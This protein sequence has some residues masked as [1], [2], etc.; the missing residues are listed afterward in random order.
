[1]V[2]APNTAVTWAGGSTQTVTWNVSGTTAS[3]IST[4]N[5]NIL[6]STDGGNTF[7]TVI[8]AT[9]ANDG[10]ESITV[11]NTATTT[12]RIKVE[13]VGNI[14]F[15]MSNTN[16]TITVSAGL[17]TIT[18]SAISPT[19]YCDGANVNVSYTINAAPNAGNVFTAQLSNSAGSFASPTAI[20][21]LTTTAAGT[22]AATIPAGTATGSGY[23]IRIVSSSPVVTG[24]DNGT[25]ITVNAKPVPSITG[26][27]SF[28]AG[29][30]T[31][32]NAGS[33]FSSYNWSTGATTQTISASTAGTFTVTV[34]NANGCSGSTA[35]TTTVNP[36]P[37]VTAD[38]V[39][40]CAGTSIALSGTPAGGT[41]SVANP[42]TG[43]STTYTHTYTDGNGCTNTS[44]SA[45]I[46][47][48]PLPTVTADNVS[49]CAGTSIALSGTPAGGTWSV[50][51]P[52]T[53]SSTTYT[54]TY[55]DGNGCTNTSTSASIT[56]NALPSVSFSGLAASYNVSASAATLTGSPAGGTFS[57][58]GISGNVFTP[59]SAG[60]GGPYTIIYFY[61][62][63][64]GCSNSS[65]HQTTVT[66]CAVPATPGSI[67]TIGGSVK[68]CPGD[69]KSYKITAVS[70][71]TSYTWTTP[72]GGVIFAG[73][74][75]GQVTVDYN[76]GF[77]AS[78]TLSVVANNSCGSSVARTLT[79]TR[80]TPATPGVI[81]GLAAGVCNSTG[82]P[83][84]IV[85]VAGIVYNWS[86]NVSTATIASGQ[87]TNA[88]TSDYNSSFISGG[89][90]VTANNACGTSATRTLSIK[91]TPATPATITGATSVCANQFGVPYSI[92]P[93]AS[94]TTYTWTGMTGSHISDGVVTSSGTVLTTT[95]TSVT[96][97]FGSTSGKLNVKANNA[98]GAG[99]NKSLTIAFT[100]RDI[101]DGNSEESFNVSIHPNPVHEQLNI[102][103]DSNESAAY[104]IQLIDLMGKVIL[105][106]N[107]VSA[108]GE[109]NFQMTPDKIAKGMYFLK[110][111][112]GEKKNISRVTVH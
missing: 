10:T 83:Y 81:T 96:V 79:I 36:L 109:N 34:T 28:C 52:Y 59:S 77:T 41:W 20:G 80:N 92:S 58:P 5:V 78:G 112:N 65:S 87:G 16:F 82:V 32:L 9:T 22:I 57:G 73:Q 7:P 100:C 24:S 51:N 75:T 15:D 46:T 2:T 47:V 55:T 53:G 99:T 30:S 50:A 64:N 29:S 8:S 110:V 31:T 23:R 1:A 44:T 27:T 84:S 33:G 90:S 4:A 108:I 70:G 111:T 105:H 106:S 38:N 48:N 12:A 101:N 39:S 11:P 17:T 13:A 26:S 74:G 85:N 98:C 54:H 97:N 95:S 63:A 42:Y 94:A 6:L 86:F 93:I 60:V 18:T 19:N 49:G 45:N 91:S 35:V 21:T 62:D 43:S 71:A 25:N 69:S 40:G 76:S 72:A 61:T 56:V 103:F 102:S 67:T 14:F 104:T 66:N 37:T 68:I 89:L 107:G 3:P 88:I